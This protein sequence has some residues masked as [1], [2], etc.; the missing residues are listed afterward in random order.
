MREC[1]YSPDLEGSVQMGKPLLQGVNHEDVLAWAYCALRP[2][3]GRGDA[4]GPRM[5]CLLGCAGW[6]GGWQGGIQGGPGPQVWVGVWGTGFGARQ[7]RL[8]SPLRW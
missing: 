4:V 2:P 5:Q 3:L 8:E 6:Q 1:Y 7:L